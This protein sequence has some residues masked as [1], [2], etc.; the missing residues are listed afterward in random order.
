MI[1][2]PDCPRIPMSTTNQTIRTHD[3]H[4]DDHVDYEY[5]DRKEAFWITKSFVDQTFDAKNGKCFLPCT[6]RTYELE[7][8]YMT[9]PGINHFFA[10]FTY[11]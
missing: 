1:K 9:T 4:R 11:T 3:G 10:F 8:T 6:S 7:Y 2:F 5:Y